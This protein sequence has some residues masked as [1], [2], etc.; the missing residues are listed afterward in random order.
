MPVEREEAVRC[1]EEQRV[2]VGDTNDGVVKR[3][4]AG[5]HEQ[6]GR[7]LRSGGGGGGGRRSARG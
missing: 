6:D 1:S 2:I 3:V 5:M 7:P 4:A